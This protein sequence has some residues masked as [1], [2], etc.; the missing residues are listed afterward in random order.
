LQTIRLLRDIVFVRG[1]LFLLVQGLLPH[2]HR[3]FPFESATVPFREKR[4]KLVRIV[5]STSVAKLS[6]DGC[7]DSVQLVFVKTQVIA[8]A[9]P[10]SVPESSP[11]CVEETTFSLVPLRVQDFTLGSLCFLDFCRFVLFRQELK[12][13]RLN[14]VCK[15]KSA[16]VTPRIGNLRID[17]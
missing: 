6:S 3:E 11:P 13:G 5:L 17:G 10:S 4:G 16:Y 2:A 8:T 1:I 15:N 9:R 14:F 12:D 7:I